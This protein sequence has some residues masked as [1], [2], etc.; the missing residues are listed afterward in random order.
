MWFNHF[1][2]DEWNLRSVLVTCCATLNGACN[3]MGSQTSI[4]LSLNLATRSKLSTRVSDANDS[5]FSDPTLEARWT[6]SS[7]QI[8]FGSLEARTL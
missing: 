1:M 7:S 4:A 8:M 5:T 3:S 2:P 6:L